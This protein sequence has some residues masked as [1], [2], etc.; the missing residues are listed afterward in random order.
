M[1]KIKLKPCPFCGGEAFSHIAF[2]SSGFLSLVV[3]CSQCHISKKSV[4]KL[5]DADFNK[6]NMAMQNAADNW[7]KRA[8]G[9]DSTLWCTKQTADSTG[10]TF[11]FA[12]LAEGRV[13]KCPYIDSKDR[14]SHKY[15]CAD[16]QPRG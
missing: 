16:Y 3:K 2:E 1:D 11:C 13:Q 8:D 6:M 4:V 9:V 12:H 10:H 15:P 5:S 14:L 7:N